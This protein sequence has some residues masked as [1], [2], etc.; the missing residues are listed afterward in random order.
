[1]KYE[2]YYVDFCDSID[3]FSPKE[4]DEILEKFKNYLPEHINF[5]GFDLDG[6]DI[7]LYI[8]QE[9]LKAQLNNEN[10]WLWECD[11]NTVELEGFNTREE[12]DRIQ[13]IL[14]DLGYIWDKEQKQLEINSIN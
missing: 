1:M 6:S 14:D 3:I 13:E 11:E 8:L 4:F 5:N 10:I 9:V 2:K 7:N 12:A